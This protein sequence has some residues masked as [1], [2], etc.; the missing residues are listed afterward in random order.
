VEVIEQVSVWGYLTWMEGRLDTPVWARGPLQTEP[1]SR[2]M[3]TTVNFGIVWEHPS[4]RYW[5]EF[6]GTVAGAQDKLS[7]GDQ[8]DTQRIPPGGTPGYEVFHLRAGWR[9]MKELSISLALENITDADFRIHG[10]GLNEPGRN[11][12]VAGE[13]RF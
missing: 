2:L 6:A 13:L 5:A 10:S 12:I 4:R 7:A 9:P 3:P 1:V 11:F 8:A